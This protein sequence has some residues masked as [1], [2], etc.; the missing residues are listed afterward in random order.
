MRWF[1]FVGFL[2]FTAFEKYNF[3]S[4]QNL[5][6]FRGVTA[7]IFFP[8]KN[9]NFQRQKNP[10]IRR[11]FFSLQ[12]DFKMIL[13]WFWASTIFFVKAFFFF[14]GLEIFFDFVVTPGGY[15]T[16]SQLRIGP[17]NEVGSLRVN[18]FFKKNHHFWL[19]S[20]FKV[21]VSCLYD[22]MQTS[23]RTLE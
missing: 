5:S 21:L 16:V 11:F 13:K 7:K 6:F 22:M 2:N 4:L 1:F 10:K 23:P 12:N 3:L 9:Q 20:G 8:Q 15:S 18:F 14:T 17:Q 19:S